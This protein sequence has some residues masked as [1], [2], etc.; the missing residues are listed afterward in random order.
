[1]PKNTTKPTIETSA[2]KKPSLK[3]NAVSNWASLAVN[4]AIGFFLTPFI[5]R[6]L[7]KT[8]FGIWTLV[9]SFIGYYGLLDLG[10]G[11]AITRYIARYSAQ[12]D[13]NAL[14]EVASTTLAMFCVTGI[15]AIAVSFSM[16]G[17]LADFFK[18]EPEQQQAFVK[19]IWIIGITT[20]IS[21]PGNVF[22]A[23]VTARE[24]FVANNIITIAR[25]LLR[26]G[27][28]ILFINMGWGLI[29]VGLAPLA[30]TALAIASSWFLF[31]HYASDVRLQ[32]VLVNKRTLEMLL[33]Y[34]GITTVIMVADIFRIQMNS[35]VIGKFVSLEAVGVYG[36]AA[37]LIRYM[38]RIIT[39]GMGVLGP[40]FAAL[41]AI[42]GHT[43]LKE[44]FLR[45]LRISALLGFGIC[46]AMIIFGPRFIIIW[47]GMD[48]EDA[49][50]VLIILCCSYA[51]ALSQNPGIPLL[52]ALNKHK[53]Y[54]YFTLI[55][56]LINIILCVIL[57]IPFGII[58]VA[59][60]TMISMATIKI[61]IMPIYICR[62]ISLTT[63]EYMK[64]LIYPLVVG[65]LMLFVVYALKLD[66]QI[67]HANIISYAL[68]C[69]GFLV[70]FSLLSLPVI[71]NELYQTTKR[72]P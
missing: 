28:T 67:F 33:V 18:V 6:H 59:L 5:I 52:Y 17:V 21:F 68:S 40:R 23:I 51:F 45:S 53:Y 27:L 10:V 38:T 19:L 39:A 56:G 20:G 58:G 54:A 69:F 1:M 7:G 3:I 32:F 49:I 34:G 12:K 22:G 9:G 26:A 41:D 65:L 31:K 24:H 66:Y 71:K 61:I 63:I 70:L 16:A 57:A 42:D 46:T 64:Q 43:K 29:G 37:L 14:N 30:A 44:L 55:E 11:S 47:V 48:Y 60:G 25:A 62:A 8:G 2:R 50:P 15:I 72:S 35:L 13:E 36:V 4:I